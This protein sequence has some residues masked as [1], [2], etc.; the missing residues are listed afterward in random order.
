[1]K[2]FTD[3]AARTWTITINVD[4]LKRVKTLLN[5]DPLD[6]DATLPRLLADPIFLCDFAYC[7]CKPEADTRGITDEDFGRA[8]AG[9]A[10]ANAKTAILE[11]YVA[12]FPEQ[13]QRET[14]TL[15]LHKSRQ[16]QNR[17]TALLKE[18]LNMEELPPPLEAALR[19]YGTASTPSPESAA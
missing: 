16:L 3:T 5:T 4:A 19:A 11:E 2:T 7:L 1:M 14:L 10:I 15:A 6:I 12:F 8:M 13:G 17:V 9:E 18:R